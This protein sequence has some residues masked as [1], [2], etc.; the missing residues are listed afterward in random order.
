VKRGNEIGTPEFM[1]RAIAYVLFMSYCQFL[2]TTRGA[3]FGLG[4]AFGV[5]H[6][7]I[8]MNVQHDANHGAASKIPWLND[9]MGFGADSIGGQKWNWFQQHWTHH[10]Y[11]NNPSKDPDKFSAEPV[12]LFNDYPLGNEKRKFFHRFQALFFIPMW[13]FYWLHSILHPQSYTLEH[14]GAHNMGLKMKNEFTQKRRKYAVAI[15]LLYIYLNIYRPLVI[16]G[17]NK[18]GIT[19]IK[20][21]FMGACGSLTLGILFSLSH[22]FETVE[23]DP[24]KSFQ[25]TGKPVCWYKAQVE[26]TST[27]GA[28]IAGALTGGLNLQVEHHLFPR[29]SSAYYPRIAPTIRAICKKYGVRYVYYPWIWQNFISTLKYMHKAGTGEHWKNPLSGNL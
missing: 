4:L 16:G 24:T 2:W 5:A 28:Y 6:A 3:S 8:G 11:T 29:M 18:L 20:I 7:L 17:M 12:T 15:R 10:S 9:L 21:L 19:M 1:G 13:S 26:T 25:E 14:A 22:N 23:R 27:Y